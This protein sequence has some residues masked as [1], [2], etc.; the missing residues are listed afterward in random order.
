[1]R[2][3]ISF[4]TISLLL[5]PLVLCGCLQDVF[6]QPDNVLYSTPKDAGLAYEPVLFQSKDGTRLSGW[7]IPATGYADPKKA[8]GTVIHFHGNAQNMTAHWAFVQ[9]LPE[10]GYNLFVFDYRGYGASEG[11][12]DPKGVFEDSNSAVNY[13]RARPDVNPDRLLLLGQSLGG[14]S[15]IDVLGSGNRQGVKAIVVESTFFSFSSIASDKVSSAGSLMDDTYSPE[16]YIDKLSPT[17]FLLIH[18]TA[19]PVIPYRHALR[20][21]EKAHEPKQLVTINGGSHTEA[22]TPRFGT[23]YMDIVSRFFDEA[24]AK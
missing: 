11:K 14:A 24:L 7:F 22:F 18:G 10:R 16:R 6:Y 21:I 3:A 2:I 8:K 9:W 5:L 19:D 13:V 17:P 1:M 23:I 4:R 15:A 20:L 12:P